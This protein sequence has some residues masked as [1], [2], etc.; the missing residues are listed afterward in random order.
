MSLQMEQVQVVRAGIDD[1]TELRRLEQECF[2]SP[3]PGDVLWED[4]C[5]K[6]S[7]YF[8][9]KQGKE[10]LGYAGI[11]MIL[12]EAHINKICIS[13]RCRRKG[14]GG[15][16]LQGVLLQAWQLG[17]DSLTLEVRKSN[18]A[19]IALYSKFG[20]EIEGVRKGYYEDTGE[21]ALIMW[22]RGIRAEMER[23]AE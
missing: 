6:R 1:F 18:A 23:Q 21:D 9:L 17:A 22:K 3:W 13:P 2:F 19:A 20:F 10:A 12:D 14:Y 4:L 15:Q 8:L 16:L 7:R 11:W 5:S